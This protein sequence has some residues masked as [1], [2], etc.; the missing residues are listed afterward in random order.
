MVDAPNATCKPHEIG[1]RTWTHVIVIVTAITK[2]A[3]YVVRAQTYVFVRAC[4]VWVRVIRLGIVVL[5]ALCV[6]LG[7]PAL[8][9]PST[10]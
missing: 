10:G 7:L 1:P 5:Y 8:G 6:G 3:R 2:V 4:R 9:H